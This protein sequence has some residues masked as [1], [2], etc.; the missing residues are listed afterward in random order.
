LQYTNTTYDLYSGLYDEVGNIDI[1]LA[2]GTPLPPD[3]PAVDVMRSYEFA[4]CIQDDA[5]CDGIDDDCDGQIDEDYVSQPTTCGVGECSST[6]QTVCVSGVEGDTCTPGTPSPEICDGLDNNCDGVVD[7]GCSAG[8]PGDCNSDTLVDAGDLTALVLEIFDDDGNLPADAPGSTFAGDPV[9]CD[10]NEDGI[11][12]A[13]DLTCTVLL[14]FNGP[15]A[16]GGGASASIAPVSGEPVYGAALVGPAHSIPFEL[17]A[18]ARRTV[19]EPG[20]FGA[21][22]T[23]ISSMGFSLPVMGES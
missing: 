7:E 5:T 21:V 8:T 17:P 23:L 16:C 19:T 2:D 6:G 12:D 11:I 1:P 4:P 20:N 13:G 18:N 15:G 3:L 10:A 14:I 9:G 22:G